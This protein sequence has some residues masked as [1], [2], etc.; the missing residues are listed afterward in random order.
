MRST[1]IPT[2]APT[3]TAPAFVNAGEPGHPLVHDLTID[4]FVTP[5]NGFTAP[6]L[7]NYDPWGGKDFGGAGNVAGDLGDASFVID[8]KGC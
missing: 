2:S 4:G 6:E 7:Q 3:P 1:T 5:A 8:P